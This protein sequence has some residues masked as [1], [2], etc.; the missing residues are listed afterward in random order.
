MEQYDID[1]Q[2]GEFA[3]LLLDGCTYSLNGMEVCGGNRG[4]VFK[5]VG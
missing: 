3:E 1:K 5:G 2:I 4:R